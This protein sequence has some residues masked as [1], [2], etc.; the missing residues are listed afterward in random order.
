MWVLLFYYPQFS[1]EDTEA[2]RTNSLAKI[3][4]LMSGRARIGTQQ[5]GLSSWSHSTTLRLMTWLV[6]CYS[7]PESGSVLDT[8]QD[9]GQSLAGLE[10]DGLSFSWDRNGDK[11]ASGWPS[12]RCP[13]VFGG[14]RIG[15]FT[16]PAPHPTP[17]QPTTLGLWLGS[18]VFSFQRGISCALL[19]AGVQRWDIGLV[20]GLDK[21]WF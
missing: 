18:L 5:S 9:Q 12:L 16:P 15:S 21:A 7:H 14:W 17:C 11:D 3:T 10:L 8:S 1:V 4:L 2:Q 13:S 20:R 19:A 6:C